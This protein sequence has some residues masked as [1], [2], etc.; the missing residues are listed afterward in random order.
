MSLVRVLLNSVLKLRS[1]GML[2]QY[3]VVNELV[4]AKVVLHS[5]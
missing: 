1:Y 4:A 2:E 5:I 3:R